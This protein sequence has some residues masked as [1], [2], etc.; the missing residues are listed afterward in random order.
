MSSFQFPRKS[1]IR[2]FQPRTIEAKTA[3]KAA[4][5]PGAASDAVTIS[6]QNAVSNSPVR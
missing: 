3:V 4:S 6:P 2:A 1:Y 5:A